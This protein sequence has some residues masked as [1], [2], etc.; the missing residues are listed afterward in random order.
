MVCNHNTGMSI[1]EFFMK[2]GTIGVGGV[3]VWELRL[4]D[5]GSGEL[6]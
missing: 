6:S 4:G 3:G 5:L 1:F 2:R